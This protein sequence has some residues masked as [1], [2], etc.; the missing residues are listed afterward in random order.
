MAKSRTGLH[1]LVLAPWAL[2]TAAMPLVLPAVAATWASDAAAQDQPLG[3]QLAQLQFRDIDVDHNGLA[4][5]DEFTAYGDLTMVSMDSDG[6]GD[7]SE[8][9]FTSWGFGMH[10]LA[11]AT[12]T[13]QGYDTALRV[14]FDYWDHDNDAE[15]SAG[16]LSD[17]SMSSFAYADTSGDVML[18]EAEF[19]DN[20][21]LNIALRNALA[22]AP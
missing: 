3:T 17:A 16:E 6:S 18:D 13:R 21:L 2:L 19:S 14:I 22:A 15:I 1:A 5:A 20:F 4:T 12:G 7:L 10:N 9:E 11:D 8:Q